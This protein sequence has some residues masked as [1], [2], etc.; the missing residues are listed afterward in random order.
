MHKRVTAFIFIAAVLFLAAAEGPLRAQQPPPSPA[1]PPPPAQAAPPAPHQPPSRAAQATER[2]GEVSFNFDDA[3]I[4][5]VIQTVFGE[6]LKVNYLIDPRVRGRVNFRTVTPVPR[7]A[8]LPIMEVLLKLNG[9]GY[10]ERNG[11]YE[12]LPL[13]EIPG[14]TPKIF[15]YPLQ[16]SKAAHI[17]TLLQSIFS[18]TAPPPAA[19]P[20]SPGTPPGTQFPAPRTGASVIATGT[21]VLVSP[22]TRV[23][24]DEITNSLIILS[25]PNDFNFIED[26]IKKLDT[27]P[28]QV[29]IEALIAEVTLTDQL[30]FGLE[31]L[32][33]NNVSFRTDPMKRS[34]S[35]NGVIGQNTADL[36]GVDLTKGVQ[37]FSYAAV[38]AA[39]K[40]KALL[41]ALA[42]ESKLNILASPHIIAA[43][44]RE[45][46]I[47]IGDQVPIATS[48]ATAVGTSNSILTTI[49]YK[50]TGT[51]LRV[52]PQ[53]NE[54]GLVALEVVQEV[55]NFSTQTVLG[56][57]QF[58]FSKREAT[59]NLVAQDGQTIV[60]GGLINNNTNKTQTGIP[61]LRSLPV[62]GYLF[63]STNNSTTRTEIIVLL[64]PHVIRN[65]QEAKTVTSDYLD[66]L[67]SVGKNAEIGEFIQGIEKPRTPG[68]PGAKTGPPPVK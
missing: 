48:Q 25:T 19:R 65:Q 27:V 50:D 68:E 8:V 67:K 37:G 62:I 15:V 34:A 47:Q 3:D 40:V 11:I 54:S 49:Q 57:Q 41:Q 66:R 10:L 45:A 14:T 29:V 24:A 6:I 38:D 26:T 21:G 35:L 60:I 53:I 51:I 22:E 31:W 9:A 52:K 18:G 5:D 43:D 42:S 12:I 28:R 56:T 61:L 59:T 33:S 4:F 13:N 36:A 2:L 20:P 32:I 39:G 17:S 58:V 1:G 7:S 30:Q 44:N 16:N 64:T 63:G 55:S 46:R 23:L